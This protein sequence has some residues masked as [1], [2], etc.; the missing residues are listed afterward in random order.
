VDIDE[1][2][3]TYQDYLIDQDFEPLEANPDQLTEKDCMWKQRK[4]SQELERLNK[5]LPNLLTEKQ[6]KIYNMIYAK[7]LS[8]RNVAKRL[9]LNPS[10]INQ[11]HK[12]IKK[13]VKEYWERN[14][15]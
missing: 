13:K 12:A 11:Q 14:K 2:E 3:K 4:N 1:K 7:G 5:L 6:Y 9:K 15:I 8:E 10:T